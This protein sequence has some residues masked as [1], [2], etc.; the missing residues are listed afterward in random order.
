MD[1][2]SIDHTKLPT[3]G[4]SCDKFMMNNSTP[5]KKLLQELH[6]RQ[7]LDEECLQVHSIEVMHKEAREKID[8]C[9]LGVVFPR[10]LIQYCMCGLWKDK[11]ISFF[12]RGNLKP[13]RVWVTEY[14]N[15]T[16]AIVE[17]SDGRNV[18]KKS[19]VYDYEYYDKLSSARIA[20]APEGDF[21]W[22]YRFLEAVMCGA[23]P[24]VQRIGEEEKGY[25]VCERGKEC[26]FIDDENARQQA[27][28][29]NW[30]VF[31]KRHTLM[32]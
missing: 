23:I 19:G 7:A 16:D 15:Q 9:A 32:K 3:E 18:R 11:Q 28:W 5:S 25:H 24:V 1:R 6:L 20:L 26:L 4:E 21:H 10:S 14:E 27:T 12:F 30:N 13:K 29:Q 31:V 2:C 22:T 17:H 8:G